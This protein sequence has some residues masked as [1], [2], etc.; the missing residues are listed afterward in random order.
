VTRVYQELQF[1]TSTCGRRRGMKPRAEVATQSLH[2]AV[3]AGDVVVAAT[4][5]L[6]E[7]LHRVLPQHARP[8]ADV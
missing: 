8:C 4:D 7:A 6:E 2:H 3:D 5:E 1:T